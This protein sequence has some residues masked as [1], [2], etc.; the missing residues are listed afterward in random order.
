MAAVVTAYPAVF[1][2]IRVGTMSLDHR[3]VVPPHGGSAGTLLGGET[4]FEQYCQHWLA[5]VDGGV[6]W[7]GGRP[8]YVRN[9]LP[10]GFE[11][12]GI[13]AHG[14]GL[15]RHPDF[16][17]RLT[18]FVDLIHAAGGFVSSQFV[19]QGG[20]PLAPSP[21]LSGYYDHRIPHPMDIDEIRWLVTEYGES[22]ALA[23]E[24]GID[25][26]ELHANHDDVLQWFLSPLTN[27]RT[28]EYGG[29][30][31]QR[32][33]LL[34]EVVASIREHVSRP[35]T[36]GLRICLDEMIDGGYGIDDCRALVAAFTAEAEVDYF[37]L[38]V[39]SNWGDPSYVPMHTHPEGAWAPLC[40]LA[41]AETDLPVVYA[42]RV[43]TPERAE[44]I[45]AARQAD[46]VAVARGIMADPTFVARAKR[47]E[48]RRIRPCIGLN[49]CIHR[50]T[51]EGLPFACG[52]NPQAG[53][54]REGGLEP[55]RR[56]RSILVIGGGPGGTETAALC[57]EQGHRV[58]LWELQPH[59]G[60]QLAVAAK[61]RMNQTYQRWIDWQCDRLGRVGVDVVLGREA[62][63]PDVLGFGADTV[64][65]ATGAL[66]RPL[67]VPGR[68]LPHVV[69]ASDVLTGAAAA[70]ARVLVVSEDDR[71]APLAVADQLAADGREVTVAFR[72]SAPSPLVGKYSMGTVL[73]TLDR[74]GVR[75]E[76]LARVIAIESEQV[77]VAHPYSGRQWTIGPF[78][79]VVLA[80]GAVPNDGLYLALSR[81]HPDV[82]VLGD[83]YAPRRMVFATRQAWDLARTLA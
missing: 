45:L 62:S 58:T 73:G 18:R 8:N 26:L 70:G 78:D 19:L 49:E 14:P 15:F 5:K 7:V 32:R 57:A 35:I 82:H 1:T 63:A 47:G 71:L 4:E 41:K 29:G 10:P 40:A 3:L 36:L 51:V 69:Q 21:T 42:G 11:P 33:R 25:A 50:G 59:L 68:D 34:R 61:A 22:A 37:S 76:P 43:S 46:L 52:V 67:A 38:D 9:P 27:Q 30:F 23:A 24:A 77:H 16:V 12:T 60:G 75:L 31:E 83:A 53:R 56:I 13:G 28:D 65:V 20:M 66:P 80:C 55:A 39:G 17:P 6:Q 48:A 2:P 72:T 79:T 64:V 54:E 74:A 81:S 44:E